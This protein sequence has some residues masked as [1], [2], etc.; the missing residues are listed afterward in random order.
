MKRCLVEPGQ[1]PRCPL[2]V[3]AHCLFQEMGVG[4]SSWTYINTCAEQ[5]GHSW[6]LGTWRLEHGTRAVV[7]ILKQY[8]HI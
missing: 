3:S 6:R 7:Q 1:I 8:V 5:G 2:Q 4:A